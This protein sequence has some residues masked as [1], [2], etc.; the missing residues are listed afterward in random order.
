MSA[1]DLELDSIKRDL[2]KLWDSA[3]PNLEARKFS[4]R[5]INLLNSGSIRAANKCHDS[6]KAN[7]W[8]KK[9]ILFAF[10]TFDIKRIDGGFFSYLD[11][12]PLKSV[13][14][15]SHVRVVPGACIRDGAF[16]GS[17]VVVMPAFVNIGSYI[18]DGTMIDSYV[19]VGSC[20]Q[21]GRNCHI[22]S[23]VV[24][25]GVLEP[26]QDLPVVIEDNCF[27]GAGSVV[28]EGVIVR[29]GC[30]LAAGV[31]LTASSRII[32]RSTG[33]VSFGEVPPYSV[34]VPGSYRLPE[35]DGL[36]LSCAVIVKK[37]TSQTRAKTSINELLRT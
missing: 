30:V 26:A 29:E 8:V 21:I 14:E 6:W 13:S 5:L 2:N 25:A 12:F 4:A 31:Y 3:Q 28:A 10:K 17:G 19:T 22:S 11:K 18:G 34:V 24:I 16:L 35:S 27:I 20:A 37:V 9:G 36:S 32:D 33:E 23:G 7:E 15:S 1:S